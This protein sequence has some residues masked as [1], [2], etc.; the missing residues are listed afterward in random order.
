MAA[1]AGEVAGETERRAFDRPYGT[2]I[3]FAPFSQ[4]F[5]LGFYEPDVVK[6]PL[7]KN[8]F[9]FFGSFWR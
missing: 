3:S 5:V 6:A 8:V 1:C 9:K 2:D 7:R 4:Q